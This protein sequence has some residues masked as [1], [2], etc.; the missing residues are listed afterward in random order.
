MTDDESF[1]ERINPDLTVFQ[2]LGSDRVATGLQDQERQQLA[3]RQK[4]PDL[5]CPGL[6]VKV[7]SVLLADVKVHQEVSVQIYTMLI[8]ALYRSLEEPPKVQ[9]PPQLARPVEPAQ[10]RVRRSPTDAPREI[11]AHAVGENGPIWRPDS[12]SDGRQGEVCGTPGFHSALQ[13]LA[14]SAGEVLA[15]SNPVRDGIR[16]GV[17][18]DLQT[19]SLVPE[20]SND[21][22]GEHRAESGGLL[23]VGFW[24]FGWIGPGEAQHKD[25]SVGMDLDGAAPRIQPDGMI[26][27]NRLIPLQDIELTPCRRPLLDL[28]RR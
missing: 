5:G 26:P 18:V 1:A 28:V 10:R 12:S 20:V 16:P 8:E 2:K 13:P 23:E 25:D 21:E 19:G 4:P 9:V 17:D 15:A 3:E 22:I 14:A 11:A 6:T 24:P 7:V 27:S